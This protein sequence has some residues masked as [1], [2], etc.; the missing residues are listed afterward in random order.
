MTAASN[1]DAPVAA[2]HP[3]DGVREALSALPG[4]ENAVRDW[5]GQVGERRAAVADLEARAPSEALTPADVDRLAAELAEARAAADIAASTAQAAR[6]RLVEAQRAVIRARA[7]AY[8]AEAALVRAEVAEREV[9]TAEMLAAL[10]EWEGGAHFV[11]Y[12]DWMWGHKTPP[13]GGSSWVAPLT[14][15]KAAHAQQRDHK[16]ARLDERA[17]QAP[18]TFPSLLENIAAEVAEAEAQPETD[19]S[20]DGDDAAPV[21]AA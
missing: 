20:S 15:R 6:G 9:K 12:Q 2:R 10:R 7:A 11:P 18:A 19:D 5:E 3:L 13:G 8:R 17:E 14:Q 1:G 21:E 16:A 4:A